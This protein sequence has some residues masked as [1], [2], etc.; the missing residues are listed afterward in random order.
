MYDGESRLLAN[1]EV[2]S[3][4]PAYARDWQ[5]PHRGKVVH[6]ESSIERDTEAL[7]L[8]Q[9]RRVGQPG[10]DVALNYLRQRMQDLGLT[11]FRGTTFDL[12]FRSPD[13]RFTN[14]AGVIPGR[15][16]DL[17]PVLV[18]AHYDSVID[19]PCVDDNATAVAV[20]LAIAEWFRNAPLE[21]DLVVALFDSEEP[22]YFHS[23]LMGSTRFYK[24][25]CRDVRFAL[26]VIMDLI[27]HDIE[28][29]SRLQ[30]VLP[31]AAELLAVTGCE[32]HPSLPAIFQAA[33]ASQ[34]GLRVVPLPNRIIGDMSD[35]HAFRQG[36]QPYLFLS[37]GEGRYY[38][39]PDDDLSWINF[40]KVKRVAKLVAALLSEADRQAPE[41]TLRR[42]MLVCDTTAFE[43]TE[44]ERVFSGHLPTLLQYLRLGERL[45]DR[46]SLDAFYSRLVPVI[47][48]A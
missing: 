47:R 5:A 38:H 18:G 8:P 40:D 25:H 46:D 48:S 30:A 15:Q 22:P 2:P 3:L 7:A 23:E 43:I 45:T 35:H 26:C 16:R 19:A 24:D 21:R 33:V 27:G 20:V 11:P 1:A 44:L 34:G 42:N 32:S 36:G 13:A 4:A 39:T 29:P 9:G 31:F 17:P 28:V 14:L 10:H 6:S 12:G 41:I 37:C